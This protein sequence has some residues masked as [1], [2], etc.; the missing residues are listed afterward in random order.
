MDRKQAE[1]ILKKLVDV[2]TEKL[3][4]ISEL[5]AAIADGDH[6]AS[7]VR[8]FKAVKDSEE[9]FNADSL[10]Q[11]FINTGKVLTRAMGGTCGPLYGT[12]FIKGGQALE[13]RETFDTEEL[14]LFIKEGTKGM[15][16]LGKAQVGDKTMVDALLP[17]VEVLEASASAG[18]EYA[19]AAEKAAVA[20]EKGKQSTKD[21]ISKRG[22][23]RYQGQASLGHI[24]AGAASMALLIS[25]F[26]E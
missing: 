2:Y 18:D 12:L 25:T 1:E 19:V 15:M 14:Y 13:G 4:Y 3:D 21:M 22:R 7:M 8:G 24:D 6:G 5:D 11:V 9:I 20:A 16:T 17:A 26:A 23:G 10:S